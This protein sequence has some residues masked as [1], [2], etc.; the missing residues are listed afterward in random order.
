MLHLAFVGF[1]IHI[2]IRLLTSRLVLKLD[3]LFSFGTTLVA[4]KS[5]CFVIKWLR[6]LRYVVYDLK[7]PALTPNRLAYLCMVGAY[8]CE[9]CILLLAF[10]S[11]TLN[12]NVTKKYSS[13]NIVL[14]MQGW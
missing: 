1:T 7:Q 12:L 9:D 3:Y 4:L 14:S 6:F 11:M 2:T 13:K 8:L 5:T 10:L